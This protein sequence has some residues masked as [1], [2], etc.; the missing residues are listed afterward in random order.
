MFSV[1]EGKD[2]ITLFCPP[3]MSHERYKRALVRFDDYVG[4]GGTVGGGVSANW[5]EGVG[6]RGSVSVS[7]TVGGSVG[8]SGTVGVRGGSCSGSF[9]GVCVDNM[10]RNDVLVAGVV[11]G[12]N[13]EIIVS[14]E[15]TTDGKYDVHTDKNI[16]KKNEILTIYP[17]CNPFELFKEYSAL[18]Q[19]QKN[20]LKNVLFAHDYTLLLGLPGTG[21]TSTVS[22]IVRALLARGQK[23]LICSYTHS[24]VDNLLS[25]IDESGVEPAFA[26]RIG[27]ESSVLPSLKR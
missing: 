19:G 26:L 16:K 20:A 6:V 2:S 21:K 15:I 24:A 18:N 4:S 3:E 22:L 11:K 9:G 14:T 27:Y 12:V 7:G 23:V 13:G 25:K 8:V 17:G 10:Q 5:S 1:P